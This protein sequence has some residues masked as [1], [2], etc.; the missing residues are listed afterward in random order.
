MTEG[1]AVGDWARRLIIGERQS[2]PP[3]LHREAETEKGKERNFAE[4]KVKKQEFWLLEKDREELRGDEVGEE[5]S[6]ERT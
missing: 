4:E 2:S 3:R 1:A 6:E 5:E